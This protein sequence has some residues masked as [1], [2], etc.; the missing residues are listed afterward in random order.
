MK[1]EDYR[2][3]VIRTAR[4]ELGKE[5]IQ[6]EGA[7]AAKGKT[8]MAEQ[9][10]VREQ[11]PYYNIWPIAVDLAQSVKLDLPFSAVEPRFRCIVL[12]FARGHEPSCLTTALLCWFEH[13]VFVSCPVMN[14]SLALEYY[15]GQNDKV[16]EWL[17][18]TQFSRDETT[19][20]TARLSGI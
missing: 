18:Y 7:S 3:F 4:Q 10:W 9:L 6:S 11:R 16:E 19:G 12:R 20:H 15:F 17:E 5:W 13:H 8:V 1:P 2:A 14:K